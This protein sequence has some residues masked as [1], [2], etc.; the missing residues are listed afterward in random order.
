M[1]QRS[2]PVQC[3][4]S[5]SLLWRRVARGSS[6][7]SRLASVRTVLVDLSSLAYNTSGLSSSYGDPA[8][9]A[10]SIWR[11]RH[12]FCVSVSVYIGRASATCLRATQ[13]LLQCIDCEAVSSSIIK[14]LQC[15]FGHLSFRIAPANSKT[16]LLR[17]DSVQPLRGGLLLCSTF[18]SLVSG[19]GCF[20]LSC[21]LCIPCSTSNECDTCCAS[22]FVCTALV[23]VGP[24]RG[25]LFVDPPHRGSWSCSRTQKN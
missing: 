24:A 16:T 17:D 14:F 21:T 19:V 6:R 20:F 25:L 23:A 18:G 2:T 15:C 12:I 1:R 11:D 5:G 22:F 13:P 8:C 3:R 10:M 7:A 9:G 4:A